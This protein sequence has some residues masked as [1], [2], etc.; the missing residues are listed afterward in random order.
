MSDHY[1][2]LTEPW[3]P[4]R[5]LDGSPM[6]EVGLREVLLQ[7]EHFASVEGET[8]LITAALYRL[9]L[10]ILHRALRGPQS[11]REAARWF[12]HGWNEDERAKIEAYLGVPGR[13]DL[14]GDTPFMQVPDLPLDGFAQSWERLGAEVGS[15][16]TTMLFNLSFR[17][18]HAPPPVTLAQ[19]ARRLLEHQAFVLGGLTRKFTHAGSGA[20]AAT[21]ALVMARGESLRETF[22]LNLVPYAP[23]EGKDAPPWELPPLS[24]KDL[25][26]LYPDGQAR[27]RPVQGIA[28]AY[29]WQSRGVKLYPVEEEGQPVVRVIAH[30][31]GVPPE[32]AER[33]RDPMTATVP[34]KDGRLI[35]LSLDRERAFWRDFEAIV[36]ERAKRVTLGGDG[37]PIT[38]SG[39][40]P[41]VLDHAM[42]V[43]RRLRRGQVPLMVF[44]Q[45]TEQGK[46][47]LSRSEAYALPVFGDTEKKV[48]A[49]ISTALGNANVVGK[50]VS[51]TTRFLAEHL[52]AVGERK[53]HRDDVAKLAQS[54]GGAQ[55]YWSALEFPFRSFLATLAER[56]DV[57]ALEGWNAELDR[58]ARHAWSVAKREAGTDARARRAV[59]ESEGY[60]MKTL[61]DLRKG[62]SDDT[63]TSATRPA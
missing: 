40:E 59:H 36:P 37:Q 20:P 44:G 8:P 7:P 57:A 13:F 47:E 14:L 46:I 17:K 48:P 54:L 29:A 61:F 24:V 23:E 49:A 38:V 45:V 55:A 11:A 50:A 60:L 33:F 58:A 10:A 15:G 56:G 28:Q 1:D 16:N 2:L 25:R 9:L 27:R 32:V 21:A 39:T 26:A 31:E 12:E 4:V 41:P 35:S 3:I 18:G 30:A 53:P 62:E 6:R 51:A 52:L 42:Q 43:C 22:A 19:A 34:L 63:S 5:P